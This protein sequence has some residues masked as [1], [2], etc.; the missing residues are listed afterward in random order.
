MKL[1]T[2]TILIL[3]VALMISCKHKP[4]A[5]TSTTFSSITHDS[6]VSISN[7]DMVSFTQRQDAT[8]QI[9]TINNASKVTI[10]GNKGTVLLINPVDFEYMDGS[11]VLKTEKIVIELKELFEIADFVDAN[12]QTVS[13][14]KPLASYGSFYIGASAN[15][16]PLRLKQGKELLI[17]AGKIPDNMSLFY[18]ERDSLGSM[19]WKLGDKKEIQKN[20]NTAKDNTKSLSPLADWQ[21]GIVCT[22]GGNN[23]ILD[24]I[25]FEEVAKTAQE[26]NDVFIVNDNGTV[27]M[28]KKGLAY[29]T[30][31]K[32]EII[33]KTI[34]AQKPL[35]NRLFTDKALGVKV[36][37]N[38]YKISEQA[39]QQVETFMAIKQL[40]WINYDCF[41][42]GAQQFNMQFVQ[43]KGKQ[44]TYAKCYLIS[45]NRKSVLSY[46]LPFN[47]K[48]GV[49]ITS[50]IAPNDTYT[51]LTYATAHGKLYVDKRTYKQ[52]DGTISIALQPTDLKKL[53][54]L[55]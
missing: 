6:V 29:K 13:D 11:D 49:T 5:S 41:I 30:I 45:Q 50:I 48:T 47:N 42:V 37:S 53:S 22:F 20:I 43:Q 18:G 7:S 25:E 23:G 46:N 15:N 2:I 55:L 8:S 36:D 34:D 54:A 39:S 33:E 40:G 38:N 51:V 26:H 21:S 27:T 19:N 3:A 16:K 35:G 28:N 1:N 24:T 31:H 17:N 44:F 10:C 9:F 32:N 12:A 52:S 4:K 14:G